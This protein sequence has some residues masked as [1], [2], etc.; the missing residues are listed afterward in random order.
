M[1]PWGL[2]DRQAQ[3]M[4]AYC[5]LGSR[6]LVASE[7]G[8]SLHTVDAHMR[9]IAHVSPIR[10]QRRFIAWAIERQ[11]MKL[12]HHANGIRAGKTA[13]VAELRE[14]LAQFDDHLPVIL[15]DGVEDY[16]IDP[17]DFGRGPIDRGHPDNKC[18]AAL[19]GIEIWK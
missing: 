9:D 2:T 12:F 7:L 1:N 10:T 8:I 6:K 16:F 4:D 18:I 5:R 19:L 13:T 11:K 3:I 14:A 17:A 15:T